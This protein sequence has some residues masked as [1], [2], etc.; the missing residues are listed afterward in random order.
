V[1]AVWLGVNDLSA[2]GETG[3]ATFGYLSAVWAEA[4]ADGDILIAFNECQ[5]GTYGINSPSF[6]T[7]R[8]DISASTNQYDYL[9]DVLMNF[10]DTSDSTFWNTAESPVYHM[11]ATGAHQLAFLFNQMLIGHAGTTPMQTSRIPAINMLYWLSSATATP[12]LGVEGISSPLEIGLDNLS[13]TPI[14]WSV[15][16]YKLDSTHYIR[17]RTYSSGTSMQILNEAL[18]ETAIPLIIDSIGT[19]LTLVGSQV[20]VGGNGSSTGFYVSGT[21]HIF[22][23]TDN[24]NDIGLSTGLRPRNIY[25]GTGIYA[26]AFYSSSLT[27]GPNAICPNGTGGEFTQSGCTLPGVM[28]NPMTAVNDLI[29]GGSSGTPTRLA[30]VASKILGTD[31]SANVG[32]I[33]PPTGT[34]SPSGANTYSLTV[35]FNSS[36]PPAAGSALCNDGSGNGTAT[37]GTP[38]YTFNWTG[39]FTAYT[40]VYTFQHFKSP[41]AI[42]ITNLHWL[43][44]TSSSLAGCTTSPVFSIYNGTSTIANLTISNSAREWDS[45]SLSVS[46][47]ANTDL[48]MEFSVAASGCTSGNSGGGFGTVTYT[49]QA[50]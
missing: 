18:N 7:L 8:E 32:W 2:G 4:K 49:M 27:T 25:A 41:Y 45:G 11:N 35:P 24:A 30:A 12:E 40:A 22:F 36:A 43:N 29:L 20:N 26:P 21:G 23:Q 46:V 37:C 15:Y 48:W 50:R 34:L 9:F 33:S 31:G 42:T 14:Q 39:T 6:V 28:T 47:S 44:N 17:L 3:A 13:S 10:P 1:L 5:G 19:P 38:P 16:G